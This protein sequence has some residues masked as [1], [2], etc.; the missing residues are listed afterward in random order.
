MSG[1]GSIPEVGSSGSQGQPIK[2]GDSFSIDAFGRWRTSEPFTVFDSKNV[3]DDDGLASNVENNPLFFDNEETSGSGTST[4]LRINEASQRLSVSATTAGTRV[5][6]SLQRFNYQPGKSQEILTTFNLISLDSGITKCVG[7]FDENNGIFLKAD[8]PDLNIV[9]RTNTSGSPVDNSV[10]QSSWNIDPMDGTGPS[11]I[12][13]DFTKT[14]IFFIDFEWLGV[15]RVRV[16]FVVDGV[17]YYVHNFLNANNLSIVYMSTPNLPIRWE[18]S[19][20]GTGSASDLDTICCAVISEGGLNPNGRVRFSG[21]TAACNAN[22]AGTT[23]AV[24]GIRLKS[25]YIGETVEFVDYNLIELT[26]SSE[27]AWSLKLNPTVAGAFTYADETH[28]AVQTAFG[29]TANTVTGGFNIAGGFFASA[30][31]SSGESS[32]VLQNALKLG[33]KID[34]TVDEIVLCVTPLPGTSN[35]DVFGGITW[36]ELS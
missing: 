36:R 14:Q 23:Y 1:G 5:R 16:G 20:D 12:T 18:I 27:L 19:N 15:G 6:Q 22:V 11:G 24:M 25:E 2:A 3:F 29:D 31:R 21:S 33:S 13:L 17:I 32:A 4:S 8:G 26:G 35:T 7:Y 34:G 28:A 9:R 10:S 30:F